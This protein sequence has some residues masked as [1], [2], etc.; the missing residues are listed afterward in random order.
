MGQYTKR[1][2]EDIQSL[3]HGG[4]PKIGRLHEQILNYADS[5]RSKDHEKCLW[6]LEMIWM[7]VESYL[8]KD[9]RPKIA[10][11]YVSLSEMVERKNRGDNTVNFWGTARLLNIDLR[12]VIARL[13]LDMELKAGETYLTGGIA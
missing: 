13:N 4:G 12:R 6:S 3:F 10:E 8:L 9:E 1:E 7:E 11:R 5:V 2:D